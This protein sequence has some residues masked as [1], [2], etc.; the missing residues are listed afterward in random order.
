[1]PPDTCRLCN[2]QAHLQ[3]SHVLPAFT[4]RWLRE[5]SGNGH[6]RTSAEP[7][8]RVQ[9]GLKRYWLCATCEGL[10]SKSETAFAGQLFHP[11]LSASGESFRY[12]RWLLHFC[13]SVSWRV[14][15]FY[16][17]EN[18]LKEWEPEAIAHVSAAETTWR[19]FLLGKRPHPG[20]FQQHLLPLDQVESTTGELAPNIN[21]YLMRAIHMDLCRGSK[22]IFTYSKFG[23]FIIFGFV[24]E[25][26]LRQWRG[27]RV[28][29]SE[30]FIEPRKYVLPKALGEYLNEK[31]RS[32]SAALDSVSDRQQS[33]IDEAFRANVDRFVGSDAVAA[34]EADIRL[35]GDDAFSKRSAAGGDER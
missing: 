7:N 19:E 8:Q 15:R 22:S 27:T 16:T 3:L 33:K 23:R 12:S 17:D 24:H 20:P 35:F 25:P 31:A 5:S 11:Y 1:M 26:N 13:T 6:L 10:F 14:L 21:R 32:M 9:D 28:H 29:A 34:M 2:A 30:G 4:Y 18:H